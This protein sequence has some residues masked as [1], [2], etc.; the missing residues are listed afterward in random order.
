[1]LPTCEVK[2]VRI[3]IL[4]LFPKSFPWLVRLV[5]PRDESPAE[6]TDL[7]QIVERIGRFDVV[8]QD[9]VQPFGVE[10]RTPVLALQERKRLHL[11]FIVAVAMIAYDIRK[12]ARQSLH[13]TAAFLFLASIRLFTVCTPQV[14]GERLDGIDAFNHACVYRLREYVKTEHLLLVHADGFVVHPECWDDRFLDY[15][16][17]GSP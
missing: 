8:V 16:Y 1:M 7:L 2:I 3:A 6:A 12:L 4:L 14:C 13:A 9:A 17:I 5:L 10:K 15:D 11:M